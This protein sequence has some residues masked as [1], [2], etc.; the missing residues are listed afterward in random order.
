VDG[1]PERLI[2]NYDSPAKSLN[3][4]KPGQSLVFLII[5]SPFDDS[6]LLAFF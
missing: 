4:A 5:I 2:Q 6:I 1:Q 3:K